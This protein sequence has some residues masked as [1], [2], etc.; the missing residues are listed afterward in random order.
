MCRCWKLKEN[1][2]GVRTLSITHLNSVC[3]IWSLRLTARTVPS[4]GTNVGSKP[5]GTTIRIIW[6]LRIVLCHVYNQASSMQSMIMRL[7]TLS[8][9]YYCIKGGD[10]PHLK[11][12]ITNMIK[13]ICCF[14]EDGNCY[15]IDTLGNDRL[16]RR[17]IDEG[18]P[19]IKWME[20]DRNEESLNS[21][22]SK[23]KTVL[24][25]DCWWRCWKIIRYKWQNYIWW[26]NLLR[27]RLYRWKLNYLD[28]IKFLNNHL[29]SIDFP[30]DGY[31]KQIYPLLK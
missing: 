21:Q 30:R 20:V 23:Y 17:R 5:A 11:F 24:D 7:K 28:A 18:N 8:K 16:Q 19:R 2:G 9:I 31:R 29:L 26:L 15:W 1:L 10:A 6:L 12:N 22:W 14:R 13:E 25:W 4:H 3:L 27:F